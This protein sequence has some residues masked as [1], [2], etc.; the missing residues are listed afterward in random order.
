MTTFC[1]QPYSLEH[2]G[3]TFES[4]EDY[5]T[6][7]ARLKHRGCEEVEIQFIDGDNHLARLA[8]EVRIGQ[9]QVAFWFEHIE[10]TNDTAAV[11]IGFLLDCGYSLEDALERYED[12]CLFDGT[13]AD[14]AAELI[15]DVYDLPDNFRYYIDYEVIARDMTI[16]GEIAEI[17]QSFI[18]TN[19][20]EF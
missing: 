19:A 4:L 5:E 9:G 2:T 15:E 11:Q 18:V 1:A 10:E 7:M 20:D 8:N 12:V 14:Y 3:F 16:N 17:C 13:P 6:G